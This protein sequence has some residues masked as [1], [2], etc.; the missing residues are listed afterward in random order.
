MLKIKLKRIGRRNLPHYKIVVSESLGKR[1]GK[2]IK[3]IGYYNPI[4]KKTFINNSLLY[5]Y[6]KHGA[7]PTD[8]VRHLIKKNIKI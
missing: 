1:D 6:I 3:E 2:F 5:N 4:T 7:Y 8:T